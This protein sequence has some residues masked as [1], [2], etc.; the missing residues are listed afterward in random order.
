MIVWGSAAQLISRDLE[1]TAG[2]QLVDGILAGARQTSDQGPLRLVFVNCGIREDNVGIC[3]AIQQ[4][5]RL[6]HKW[7]RIPGIPPASGPVPGTSGEWQ[8]ARPLPRR[9]RT[10]PSATAPA[11]RLEWDLQKLR[12]RLISQEA[13]TIRI[14]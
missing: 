14:T 6:E 5:A 4:Q 3:N 13:G 1:R 7:P 12:E 11:T 8:E 2:D 10:R 9:E